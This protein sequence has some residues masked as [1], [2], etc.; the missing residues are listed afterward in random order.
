M[1]QPNRAELKEAAHAFIADAFEVLTEEHVLPTPRYHPYIHVG[2]D[3]EGPSL[4]FLPAYERLEELLD[5]A[6]PERFSEPLRR[7]NGEFSNH[8]IFSLIEACV[9]RCGEWD[10][11]DAA[12]PAVSESIDE[13]LTVLDAPSQPVAVVRALGHVATP[14]GQPVTIDGVEVVPVPDN[15]GFDLFDECRARIPGTGS[16]FNREH[17]FFFA[18]PHALLCVRGSVTDLDYYGA[19]GAASTQLDEFTLALRLLTGPTAQPYFEVRGP[20]T[21]VGAGSPELIQFRGTGMPMTRRTAVMTAE[22][23][24]PIQGLRGL[25]DV[26]APTQEGMTASSIHVAL[27]RFNSAFT[28]DFGQA[29]VDLA[30]ALEAV[31][32]DERDGTEGITARLRNRASTLLATHADPAANIFADVSAFYDLRSR[33]IHGA[34]LKESKFRNLVRDISTLNADT[35]AFGIAMDQAIDRMRDLARR[36]ILARLCLATGA[37]PLWPLSPKISLEVAFADDSRRRELRDSWR[38]TL[39]GIGAGKYAGHL[40]APGDVLHEDYGHRPE[41]TPA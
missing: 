26:V 29:V 2:R 36:A 22:L 19:T 38:T 25:L 18:R 20:C 1:G 14:D 4:M 31:L 28:S 30:T 10:E 23:E 11:F 7:R 13:L 37:E 6:Y 8:Y 9:R 34:N 5:A 32:I 15:P 41:P 16:A 27:R 35:G 17:P 40:A 3:Y 12:S 39:D 33:L 24:R 21:L